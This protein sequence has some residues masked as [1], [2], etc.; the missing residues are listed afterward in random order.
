MQQGLVYALLGCVLLAAAVWDWRTHRVPNWLTYGA[1]AAGVALSVALGPWDAGYTALPHD[2]LGCA[3]LSLMSMGLGLL[4]M[5]AIFY[6][7]GL[8]G[9]DVKLMGAVGAILAR[10]EGVLYAFVYSFLAA[11][12][13]AVV[14][15]LH[16]R[17]VG[18][19][20]R[21]ILAAT[22]GFVAGTHPTLPADSPRVPFAVAILIGGLLSGWESVLHRALPWSVPHGF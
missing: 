6:F 15:M 17:I 16:R 7:G 4:P 11:I 3:G 20:L 13:L 5:W 14:I 22:L 18:Q 8:G 19:T 1:I 2:R 9:G 10:P 21:R 12:V